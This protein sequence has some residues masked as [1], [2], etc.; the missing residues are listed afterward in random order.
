MAIKKQYL[1]SKPVCKVT[2]SVPA[3]VAGE[4]D[5]VCVVGNFNNWDLDANPMKK[6]KKDGSF[7]TTINFDAEKEY[8]FRYLINGKTWANEPEADNQVTTPYESENSVL[9]L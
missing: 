4:A 6:L 9:E 8:Q 2:F 7:S 3:E 1:K 5:H